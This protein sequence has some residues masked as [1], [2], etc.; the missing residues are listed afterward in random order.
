MFGFAAA[1]LFSLCIPAVAKRGL[2]ALR[3]HPL[4]SAFFLCIIV[5]GGTFLFRNYIDIFTRK[6]D[7]GTIYRS[8]FW[9]QL[10]EDPSRH[11]AIDVVTA[12]RY[13]FWKG[14]L[15]QQVQSFPSLDFFFGRGNYRPI[16]PVDPGMELHNVYLELW[17]KYGLFCSAGLIAFLV[18]CM[19]KVLIRKEFLF[20]A[21]VSV[22]FILHGFFEDKIF[23][24]SLHPQ[25]LYLYTVLLLPLCVGDADR[26]KRIT[27]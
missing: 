1:I 14:F 2:S 5:L 23:V 21:G 26:G 17:G 3:R 8:A 13:S 22:S 19:R 12:N 6:F 20:L 11:G 4:W 25:L 16:N 15:V 24:N 27:S 7:N 9:N 18:L 10:F